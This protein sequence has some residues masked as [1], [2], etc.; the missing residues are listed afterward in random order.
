MYVILGK[1]RYII[2]YCSFIL[3]V[4]INDVCLVAGLNKSATRRAI[5]PGSAI[6]KEGVDVAN[7]TVLRIENKNISR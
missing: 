4:Q 2:G 7:L 3:T 5:S 1:P 6:A